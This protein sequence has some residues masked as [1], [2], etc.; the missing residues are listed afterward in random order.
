MKRW[1]FA[2]GLLFASSLAAPSASDTRVPSLKE[3]RELL[4]VVCPGAFGTDGK[5][6][7]CHPCPA[8][9]KAGGEDTFTL[10]TVA[11]GHFLNRHE[12]DAILDFSGCEPHA[13]NFG[14]S[15]ILRWKGLTNWSFVRFEEGLRTDDCLKY[16]TR[17]GHDLLVCQPYYANMGFEIEGQSVLDFGGPKLVNTGLVTLTSNS[18]Q[19]MDPKFN[20]FEILER[21][22]ID[23]DRDGRP[24]LRLEI[25]ESHWTAPSTWKCGDEVPFPAGTRHR[26]E[27]IFDKSRFKPTPATAK[28]VTYL[29]K[30]G[31]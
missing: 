4:A 24:D 2:L 1:L 8:F 13:A 12:T 30:F 16:R 22:R 10:E 7:S 11:Y 3:A 21:E 25:F 19:C 28:L 5:L 17:D 23:L 9:I 31:N 14:G 20:R 6:A 27:F 26:L 15:V 18:G 29:E